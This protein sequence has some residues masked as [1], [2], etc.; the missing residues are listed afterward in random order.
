MAQEQEKALFEILSE[1]GTEGPNLHASGPVIGELKALPE[2]TSALVEFESNY[3]GKWV[4]ACSVV[5]L[6]DRDI[7]KKVVLMFE[8]GKPHSPIIMGVLQETSGSFAEMKVTNT[9]RRI[10]AVVDG[11]RI[12]LQGSKQIILQ[13]GEAS[14][15]LTRAGK[16]LIRGSYVLSRSSGVNKIKGGSVQIN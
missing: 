8:K 7:G 12:I 9:D 11:E 14:I 16:I 2:S 1:Y 10:E 6:D 13:C 4:A 5:K 3:S 15:T